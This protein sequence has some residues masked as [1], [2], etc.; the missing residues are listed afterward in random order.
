MIHFASGLILLGVG[1]SDRCEEARAEAQAAW[2]VVELEEGSKAV[3]LY[4]EAADAH[5]AAAEALGVR[6]SVFQL[7]AHVQAAQRS[8]AAELHGDHF[9]PHLR[10]E[11]RAKTISSLGSALAAAEKILASKLLK[12]PIVKELQGVVPSVHKVM[13]RDRYDEPG[14]EGSLQ[15]GKVDT[16]RTATAKLGDIAERLEAVA[17]GELDMSAK[18]R[19]V[20]GAK[21]STG[22]NRADEVR[23]AAAIAGDEVR[24]SRSDVRDVQ[25]IFSPEE[26]SQ[27]VDRALAKTQR[28]VEVCW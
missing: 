5:G 18:A 10:A 1:C 11:Y 4:G 24:G 21:A 25:Y 28:V 17:V 15:T 12:G 2:R 13:V 9:S 3:V 7:K 26:R 16:L 6:T 14:R 23:R 22:A 8:V 20:A 27:S 19:K